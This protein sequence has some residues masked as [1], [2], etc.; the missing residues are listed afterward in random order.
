MAI[1][2]ASKRK[3]L[4]SVSALTHCN[5]FLPERLDLERAALG[6]EFS[7]EVETAW[8]KDPA[9]DRERP[10]IKKLTRLVESLA[11]DLR[12]TLADA[13]RPSP[14]DIMLYEDLVLYLLYY[15][16]WDELNPV[17]LQPQKPLA[18]WPKF[19]DDF[20]YFLALPNRQFS[21]DLEVAHVLAIFYQIRRAFHYIFHFVLGQSQP[22]V[23]L[24]AS[25]WQSIFTYD[26]RR[27]RRSLHRR[28]GD[29]ATLVTGPSGTGKELVARAVGLS[30]YI[31]FDPKR[32]HF[33]DD[34]QASFS[35]IHLAAMSPTLIES[36]LFGH[37]RGSFTGATE[38]HEGWLQTC[39]AYGSVFLDEIGEVS[40]DI[41]VKLLRVLQ[42]REF[43]RIGET[44]RRRFEGKVIAAT[45]RDLAVEMEHGRFRQ[46]LY[47]RLCADTIVTPSLREQLDDS[48]ADLTNLVRYIA[49]RVAGDDMEDLTAEVVR[50]IEAHLGRSYP[51]TGNFRELEQCVRNVMIHAEYQPAT[52]PEQQHADPR[53]AIIA[54]VESA[55]L[56][57]DELL[58]H[59]CALIYNRTGS[60]EKAA[61]KLKLD[62]RTVKSKIDKW[63]ARELAEE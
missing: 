23:K 39:G 43:Q 51:W 33:V 14:A 56:S 40:A 31:P 15:R 57:A 2:D 6:R 22:A 13:T 1:V 19:V 25:I 47:Y 37:R 24:R 36:E 32:R 50:W 18:A 63:N 9:F 3:L 52:R 8:S 42:S 4:E 30:R 27:Y 59:Y 60:Y 7:A 45:N 17:T 26:M 11:G 16:V 28:M 54:G 5:P 21:P 41:Q 48:P 55:C 58:Q 62:R 61:Q 10:N 46:D 12:T 35:A 49:Q 29:V 34:C 44:E 53:K 20:N 38:D